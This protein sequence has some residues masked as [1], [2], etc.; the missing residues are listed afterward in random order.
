[1]IGEIDVFTIQDNLN[2]PS[3]PTSTMTFTQRGITAFQVQYWNGSA[4]ADVPGGNVTGNN[5]V[6]RRFIFAPL[7]TDPIRV[8]GNNAA[9][10]SFSTLAEV[11][12]WTAGV[13]ATLT[14]P[15]NNTML[16]APAAVSLSANVSDASGPIGKVEFYRNSTLIAAVSTPTSGT[17]T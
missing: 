9:F 3:D 7:V 1:S 15:A 16:A 2:A 11:E 8:L 17:S 5:L 13:A 10:Q 4:W 14:A 12:A 6:W